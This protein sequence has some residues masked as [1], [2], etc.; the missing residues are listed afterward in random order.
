M[1]EGD[2]TTKIQAAFRGHQ[3]RDRVEKF[4]YDT[5][6]RM[7]T[8]YVHQHQIK[9]LFEHL[10]SLLA[11]ERPED[12]R[13]FLAKEL[14]QIGT[15]QVA[16]QL[17]TAADVDSFFDIL[18]AKRADSLPGHQVIQVLKQLEAP[19]PKELTPAST[20]SREEFRVFIGDSFDLY[21]KAKSKPKTTK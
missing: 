11:Y 12:P 16:T 17:V 2:A 8:D 14:H 18:D 13:A 6:R 10:L 1:D 19:I 3:D 15:E 9:E 5:Q 21:K 4:K 20:I 7:V